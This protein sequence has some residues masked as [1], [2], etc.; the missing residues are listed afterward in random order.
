LAEGGV[1]E[2]NLPSG[3]LARN[4]AKKP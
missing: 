3:A 1:F 2:G 4:K